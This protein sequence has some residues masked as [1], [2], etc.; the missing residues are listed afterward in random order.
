MKYIVN[1][2]GGVHT[3]PDE[4]V[5]VA[6][7][8]DATSTEVADYQAAFEDHSHDPPRQ[9]PPILPDVPTHNPQLPGVRRDFNAEPETLPSIL[10]PGTPIADTKPNPPEW[11]RNNPRVLAGQQAIPPAPVAG[12]VPLG[13]DGKPTRA[14]DAAPRVE[15]GPIPVAVDL[16]GAPHPVYTDPAQAARDAGMPPGSYPPN[17]TDTGLSVPDQE[18][19]NDA[20]AVKAS[21][22]SKASKG[23]EGAAGGSGDG[24]GAAPTG[25][26]PS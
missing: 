6:G 14:A 26:Q 3:V 18:V 19:T 4:Y 23:D 13:A 11:A 21:K 7:D 17:A 20:A 16:T 10:A 12:S 15:D 9:Y 24:T 22:A 5:Y 25:A 2:N 1:R 8:R